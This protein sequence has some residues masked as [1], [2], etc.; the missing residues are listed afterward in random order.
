M[1]QQLA[2]ELHNQHRSVAV[3]EKNPAIQD[4]AIDHG[5]LVL[6]GDATEEETLLEA[7]VDRAMFLVT[8]LPSDAENVFITLT[9]RNLNPELK[10]ISRAEQKSTEKKLLQAGATQVVMPTVVG[11][12]Q[13]VRMITHPTTADL[14]E[15]VSE[16]SFED[17]EL[18]EIE[19][20]TSSRLSGL[21]VAETESWRRHRLLVVAIRRCNGQYVFNPSGN[22]SLEIGD[23]VV[24][25]GNGKDIRGFRQEYL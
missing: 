25:I 7:G 23:I 2:D 24:V 16:T 1:G 12:R 22:E 21:T 6:I 11:A 19:I 17:L 4:D 9:A 15:R 13:M 3:I 18:D 5:F 14:M 20:A 8:G 10:I